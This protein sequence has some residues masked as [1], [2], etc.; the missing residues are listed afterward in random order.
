MLIPRKNELSLELIK[1]I[2]EAFLISELRELFK[3]FGPLKTKGKFPY[4]CP[5]VGQIEGILTPS[6]I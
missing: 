1:A 4:I 5:A 2:L 3:Y 6:V